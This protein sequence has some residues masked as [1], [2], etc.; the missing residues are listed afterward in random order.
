MRSMMRITAVGTIAVGLGLGPGGSTRAFAAPPLGVGFQALAG[1]GMSSRSQ[2]YL[3]VDI[4]DVGDEQIAALKL[5]E[6]RG[7]E[8]IH[9]DH[10]GPA[11]K[12]GLREHDVILQV[13]GQVIEGEDQFRRILRETP[14]GRTVTLILSRDGVQ[15]IITTQLANR[16]EVER[17]AWEQRWRVP[18]PS[19]EGAGS[20][21]SVTPPAV[22]SGNSNASGNSAGTKGQSF[23]SPGA[24]ARGGHNLIGA[25]SLGSAYTGAMV[26]TMG[27]QLAEFFGTPGVGVLVHS[28]DANSPAANAGLRAG[29]VVIRANA[30]TLTTSGEWMKIVRENRGK[31]VQVV[32]LRDKKEQTLTLV[33][34]SKKR[35]SVEPQRDEDGKASAIA[36]AS[37]L[38]FSFR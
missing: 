2:G 19:E 4:R 37:R 24:A 12:A 3:G 30:V 5:K 31:P 27:P 14:A 17:Q 11:G 33:P 29:D 20:G 8:V 18:V 13:N 28:V 9:V 32:V 7:A 22:G 15:L 1:A 38:G 36:A 35:S 10:D 26:E 6:S 16:L 25:L 23:F 34:D 21:A